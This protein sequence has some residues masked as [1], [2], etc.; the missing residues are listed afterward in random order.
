M[1]IFYLCSLS[2]KE[3]YLDKYK[4]IVQTCKKLGHEVYS[5]H[6]FKRTVSDVSSY[7]F[8]TH[9]KEYQ[10]LVTLMKRSDAVIAEIT[11]SSTT[12]GNFI[13]LALQNFIPTLLLHQSD[14]HGLVVGDLNRLIK[15]STY[16]EKN[17]SKILQRFF[18]FAEKRRLSIRFN[19]MIDENIDQFLSKQSATWNVSKAEYL[20]RLIQQKIKREL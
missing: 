17:I 6:V 18:K 3:K 13:T 2:G 7:N 11:F 15:I 5:D 12:V 9:K 16:S 4:L 14:Y 19:M 8:K 1:K 20:R 10:K